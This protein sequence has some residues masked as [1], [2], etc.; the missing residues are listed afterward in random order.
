LRLIF[1]AL[2]AYDLLG[3]CV[4]LIRIGMDQR[5]L[6]DRVIEIFARHHQDAELFRRLKIGGNLRPS[7]CETNLRFPG[8][9]N[10]RAR[11]KTPKPPLRLILALAETFAEPRSPPIAGIRRLFRKSR[12]N[13][14][15]VVGLGGLEPPTKRL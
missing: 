11:D 7:L 14:D 10:F 9:A 5:S 15:C 13:G 4:D 8:N 6:I 2:F 12:Q 3:F 1:G